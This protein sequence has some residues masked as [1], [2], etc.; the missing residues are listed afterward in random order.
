M[1]WRG[2]RGERSRGVKMRG[3]ELTKHLQ[4]LVLTLV[5]GNRCSTVVVVLT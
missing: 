5:V 3:A 1:V 2:G 4:Q